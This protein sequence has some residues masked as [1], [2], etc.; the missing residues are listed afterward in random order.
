LSASDSERNFI[1]ITPIRNAAAINVR[2]VKFEEYTT[3]AK[4]TE[5]K[6]KQ[7]RIFPHFKKP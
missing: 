7:N 2:R 1:H 3:N 5:D 4:H 6:N